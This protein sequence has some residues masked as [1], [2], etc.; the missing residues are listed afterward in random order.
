MYLVPTLDMVHTCK[1]CTEGLGMRLS[2]NLVY[3]KIFQLFKMLS[4][5]YSNTTYDLV[6]VQEFVMNVSQCLNLFMLI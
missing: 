6:Y 1:H 5:Q 3:K 4:C 2:K